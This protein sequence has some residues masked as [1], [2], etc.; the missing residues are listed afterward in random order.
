[1][2]WALRDSMLHI[3]ATRHYPIH[4][5]AIVILLRRNDCGI[6]PEPMEPETLAHNDLIAFSDKAENLVLE[7]RDAVHKF[8]NQSKTVVGYGAS[9]KA[10]QW[11]KMC[12]FTRKHIQYVCDE[13][14]Q[15]QYK[16]MP[17]TDIPVVHPSALTREVPDVAVCFA[18]NFFS[19]I[20]EKEAM[21]SSRGGKWIV[22]VPEVK[23]V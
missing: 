7:L 11:I 16:L 2:E 12:G 10:T 13:T 23:I 17:G 19:E 6:A 9:A 21:F 15:K 5:G 18:W 14:L 8:V 20:Y 22:P 3:H 4:G 1:M